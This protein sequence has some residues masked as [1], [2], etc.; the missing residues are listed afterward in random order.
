ME[1]GSDGVGHEAGR[2]LQQPALED[3]PGWGMAPE[4]VSGPSGQRSKTGWTGGSY[5][6]DS[7]PGL[8]CR[9]HRG[10]SD[11]CLALPG[12]VNARYETMTQNASGVAFWQRVK[13]KG[14]CTWGLYAGCISVPEGKL[15][16]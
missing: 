7:V 12:L 6:W 4:R 14:I 13:Q 3:S 1:Q 15:F 16:A 9:H 5:S 11:T 2:S 8:Y 10:R